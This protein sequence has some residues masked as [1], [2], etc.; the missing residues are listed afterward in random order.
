[1]KAA[2]PPEARG[3]PIEVWFQDAARVGQQGTVTRVWARRGSRPRAP[4]D[5]RHTWA[6][7]FGA[8]CPARGVGAALVPPEGNAEAT[9]PHLAEIGRCVA[10]GAPPARTPSS[11]STA[12]AGISRAGAWWRPT[13]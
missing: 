10:P 3:K 7:L 6:W 13:T 5:R 9:G 8:A 12:P 2:L 11:C 4:R 1:M